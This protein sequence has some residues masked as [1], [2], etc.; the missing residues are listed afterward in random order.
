MITDAVSNHAPD[1]EVVP[2]HDE[3]VVVFPVRGAQHHV[4]T[5]KGEVLDQRLLVDHADDDLPSLGIDP[6]VDYQQITTKDASPLHTLA[7]NLH[8]VSTRRADVQ[9][10]V[11]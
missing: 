3:A 8:Q 2:F 10:L 5:H 9:E 6:L 4:A 7:L 11:Q 1:I